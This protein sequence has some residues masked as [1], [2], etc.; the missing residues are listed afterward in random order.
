ALARIQTEGALED[1]RRLAAGTTVDRLAATRLL[2]EHQGAE[3]Q[4]FLLERALDLE[5]AVAAIALRRLQQLDPRSITPIVDRLVRSPDAQVR[6]LTAQM[7]VHHGTVAAVQ[8]LSD[9]MADVN[10]DLRLFAREALIGLDAQP[11]LSPAIRQAATSV[12]DGDNLH[13]RQHAIVLLGAVDH[14][15]AAQRLVELLEEDQPEIYVTAAWSLR[16]LA[17]PATAQPIRKKIRREIDATNAMG[18]RNQGDKGPFAMP[19]LRLADQVTHLLEALGEIKDRDAT[20]LFFEFLPRPPE[21]SIFDPPT[22]EVVYFEDPRSAALW[23]LAACYAGEPSPEVL[24][25]VTERFRDSEE[26]E[27]IRAM[28]AI[29]LGRLASPSSQALLRREFHPEDPYTP[30]G[31][32]SSWALQQLTGG[33]PHVWKRPQAVQL[34]W[35]LEP[36]P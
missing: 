6:M 30:L 29:T 2:A 5:P 1:A 3:V 17:V 35:F 13:A 26:E 31:H 24:Q 28:A 22:V 19:Q 32:A 12:M 34:N 11:A 25:A 8:R 21:T 27:S 7:L 16:K 33:E 23:A 18:Q 4:Q 15:P 10:P 14:E 20:A 9:L 36:L